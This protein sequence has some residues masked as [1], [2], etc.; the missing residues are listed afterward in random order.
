ML[1][2]KKRDGNIVPFNLNKIKVAI[3]KAFDAVGKTTATTSSICLL[4]ALR[5]L[6]TTR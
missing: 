6:S 5:Q 4:C 3:E 2:I 1:N